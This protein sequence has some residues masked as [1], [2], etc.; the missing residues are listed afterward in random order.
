MGFFCMDEVLALCKIIPNPN[1]GYSVTLLEH[2]LL[3][4]HNC[5]TFPLV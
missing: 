2:N 4:D 5:F 1:E 3:D